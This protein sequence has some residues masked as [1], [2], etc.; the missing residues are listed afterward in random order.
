LPLSAVLKISLWRQKKTATPI[1][2][3][4]LLLL[5]D[6]EEESEIKSFDELRAQLR[7]KY[8]DDVFERR[9]FIERD[10]ATEERRERG[11][12]ELVR[13]LA[14]QAVDVTCRLSSDHFILR[15]WPF[16][17]WLMTVAV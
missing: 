1:P 14:E 5:K 6:G 3:E 16:R 12:N 7:D 8:P 2:N 9:L 17:D 10:Q 11:L 13:L 4:E 15:R